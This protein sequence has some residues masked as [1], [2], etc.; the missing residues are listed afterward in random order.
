M[1]PCRSLDVDRWHASAMSAA[2]LPQSW[3]P[4]G[5]LNAALLSLPGASVVYVSRLPDDIVLLMFHNAF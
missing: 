3:I 4:V 1:P 2:D 5:R